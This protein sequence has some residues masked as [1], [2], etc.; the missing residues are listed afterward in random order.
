VTKRRGRPT[1]YERRFNFMLSPEQDA[2]LKAL[3][4]RD[5]ISPSEA[6]RRALDGFLTRKGVLRKAE[7]KKG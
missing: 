4:R 1:L 2:A 7:K 5:D 3:H 6:T